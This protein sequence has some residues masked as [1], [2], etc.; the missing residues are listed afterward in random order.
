[1]RRSRLVNV[2]LLLL[3]TGGCSP[4]QDTGAVAGEVGARIDSIF[5]E[6]TLPGSPGATVMVIRE[7]Q[8]IHA[9]G[10]GLADLK[11]GRALSRETP[12]RLGSVGKQFTSMGIMILEE[13]EE[14]AFDQLVTEW[15]P[16]L[17]RFPGSQVSHLLHHTSG[18]PD[19]Y[20]LPDETLQGVAGKDG[21]P[22]LTNADVVSIYESWGD[23]VF[24][25]G[26][27]FEY[28]N[29][30]Y[31][32]LGLIIERISGQT[33][34]TFLAENIFDP[35]NMGTAVVRERPD[36]EIPDRAVGY[37][38]GEEDG[39]W[40]ENDHHFG[41]WLVGAGGVYAS[42]DDLYIWDQALYADELVTRETLAEAFTP[43]T[44]NDGSVS[45]Y[46]FGWNVGDRLGHR[47]VHHGGSW[48]G[49]RSG[50]LRFLD[51]GITV[52]VLSNASASAGELADQVAG[53]FL[54]R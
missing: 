49:F 30:G 38:S 10:Y 33:F 19:Y 23:P 26:D 42:L 47:A 54:T 18:L 5:S 7:G 37:S 17:H 1:M 50:I 9:K 48:V 41:N 2:L 35:L 52:I 12:V 39:G 32:V 31:E 21:H 46:G 45:E 25:P 4:P 51:E 20:D 24:P 53:G 22:L 43:T 28:S 13:R 34:G 14:L 29:P 27:R 44:L 6:F 11:S 36:M 3:S 8:V 16:E 40:I 15:V